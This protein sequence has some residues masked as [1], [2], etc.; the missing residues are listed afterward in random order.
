MRL[1]RLLPVL[2]LL[3][4][5]AGC[6]AGVGP[7]EPASRPIRI[8]LSLSTIR[9]ERWQRD[10]DIFI[11]RA[12]ELGAEVIVQAAG[13]DDYLQLAQAENML[14]RGIDVLVV[15]PHSAPAMAPIVQKAHEAGVKV[16]A[17]DRLITQ[18]DIDLYI[19]FDNE[20]VGE[21][22]AAYL[23]RLVPKGRYAYI[24][25]APTDH[26]VVLIRR[27][28]MRVLGPLIDR[29]DIEIVYEANVR[30]WLPQEAERLA[31]EALTVTGGQIDA[32]LANNDGTAGGIVR[33]LYRHGLAG[34]I[35]V[36]GQDADLA[37]VRRVVAGTQAM[38]IYKPIRQLA[39][40]AAEVAVAMARGEAPAAPQQV[41]NGYKEVPAILFEPILVE[42]GNV[43][44]TV[45]QD[46][47]HRQEEVFGP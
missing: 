30:D 32:V 9:D 38:T 6:G 7:E 29:G 21:M 33:A 45:I 28:A 36:T 26:N 10:R 18:A 8:G 3:V 14:H 19:S 23:T 34:K 24:G 25:G 16:I 42:K 37:A 4:L 27:G 41:A 13:E 47:F 35:P 43:M 15:V 17:Y 46:G 40:K 39:T 12:R 20:R 22:Q 2:A 44:E 5:A 31:E 1:R 11:A